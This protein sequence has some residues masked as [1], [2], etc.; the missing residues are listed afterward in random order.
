MTDQAYSFLVAGGMAAAGAALVWL[1]VRMNARDRADRDA[2]EQRAR[3][4]QV[5]S[6]SAVFDA[7]AVAALDGTEQWTNPHCSPSGKPQAATAWAAGWCYG[8]QLLR[9]AWRAEP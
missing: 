2:R 8:R 6:G 4:A 3:A 5:R 7:G 1:L 9:D